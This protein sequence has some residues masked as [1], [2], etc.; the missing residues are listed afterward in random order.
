MRFS[1]FLHCPCLPGSLLCLVCPEQGPFLPAALSVFTLFF[2]E[3]SEARAA[4][5]TLLRTENLPTGDAASD[6]I[7]LRS[8]CATCY[9]T[10][11]I[12][13][14]GV[15]NSLGLSFSLSHFLGSAKPHKAYVI[16][17]ALI[18]FNSKRGFCLILR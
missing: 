5:Q 15:L 9:H 10:A 3:V 1:P 12:S 13:N 7:K 4:S 11:M 17:K 18:M 2:L 16:F 6:A 14:R 8:P